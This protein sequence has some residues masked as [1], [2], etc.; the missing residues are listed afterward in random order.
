MKPSTLSPPERLSEKPFKDPFYLSITGLQLKRF[1]H[2]VEF[3]WHSTRSFKHA[4]K[5]P[6]NLKVA[7]RYHQGIF[8]TISAWKT[9]KEM[10]A[11]AFMPPHSHA[12]RAFRRIA[13]G[14]TWGQET[15][16]LPSWEE[17]FQV[18]EKKAKTY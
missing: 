18:Y 16:A 1:W 5:A 4:E 9:K 15:S 12:I 6:G 14:K 10:Q 3:F 17:V 2:I 8:F 11:F 7:A 13:T